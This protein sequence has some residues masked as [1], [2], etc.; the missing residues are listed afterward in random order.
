MS[1]KEGK[2]RKSPRHSSDITPELQR[3]SGEEGEELDEDTWSQLSG[4]LDLGEGF[5][6]LL[7]RRGKAGPFE[8]LNTYHFPLP[9]P[10]P[11]VVKQEFGGGQ[12]KAKVQERGQW[13]RFPTINFSVAGPAK[14]PQ[15]PGTGGPAPPPAGG[16]SDVI[17]DMKDRLTMAGLVKAL[18][19]TEQKGSG[20]TDQLQT[21][22]AIKEL[23]PDPLE[24][25]KA[26]A[27]LAGLDKRREEPEGRSRVE[28]LSEL[29]TLV[30]KLRGLGGEG[31]AGAGSPWVQA[32]VAYAPHLGPQLG[33]LIQGISR[34]AS[35]RPMP[36]APP[37]PG[38]PPAA[39][40]EGQEEPMVLPR[41]PQVPPE[42]RA[43][44][45]PILAKLREENPDYRG[46]LVF[47]Q[48]VSRQLLEE[49]L[50]MPDDFA[51]ARLA[52]LDPRL[53]DPALQPHTRA[54]LAA[55]R[56]MFPPEEEGAE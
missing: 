1:E 17:T 16:L 24:Q 25:I 14:E 46:I 54:L 22:K 48:S 33:G 30:E 49:V 29:L 45:D 13:T 47:L 10:L 15:A 26:I 5:T 42:V 7:W 6:L 38:E 21:I 44:T 37:A 55:G 2:R 4:L 53:A 51:V 43:F 18:Q 28:E 32:L 40:T 20:I 3:H 23:S 31:E 36:G 11:E 35:R 50:D 12:Y 56:E 19:E 34:M 8:Y 52:L 9:Q 41:E 27:A 39:V